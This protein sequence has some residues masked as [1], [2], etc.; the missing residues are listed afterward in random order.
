[1]N[2]SPRTSLL[3][4]VAGLITLITLSIPGRATETD[5]GEKLLQAAQAGDLKTIES[6]LETGVDVNSK[7]EYGATALAY[8][9]DK[10]HVEVVKFLIS[11]GADV[12]ATDRF[13]NFNPLTWAR[14]HTHDEIIQILVEA[15]AKTDLPLLLTGVQNGDEALV[16]AILNQK[17][18]SSEDLVKALTAA[19]AGEN[20]K[21][22]DMLKEAGAELPEGGAITVAKEALDAYA[23]KYKN[24]Q[25]G[26]E[27]T[28]RAGENKVL[29]IVAGQQELSY[30]PI[31]QVA[32]DSVEF[33][34]IRLI[35]VMKDDKCVGMKS[36]QAQ[37][38]LDWERVEETPKTA[39]ATPNEAKTDEPEVAFEEPKGTVTK[40]ANWARFRGPGASGIADGQ[41]PPTRW[42]ATTGENILWKAPIPGL[43][44]SS[45]IVWG[46]R[47]FVTTA[48]STAAEEEF[49]HGLYGDFAYAEDYDLVHSW[50]VIC[51]DR[52]SG[53]KIWERTAHEGKPRIKRHTKSS[54]T[55]STPVTDGKYVV[56]ILGSEGLFCY[57]YEGN[58]VW[59]KDLGLL[60]AGWFYDPEYQFGFGSSPFLYE[61]LVIVQAD[62][63]K[64]PFL[65]AYDIAT[66]KEA[67]RVDRDEICSWSSPNVFEV[68]G[69]AELV[70]NGTKAIRGHDPKTGK[71]L[72]R[73]VGNSEVCVPTPIMAHGLIYITSGYRPFQPIYALRPGGEGD[74]SL[75]EG[76]ETNDFVAW[77]K[78]RGGPYMQTP[79]VYGDHLYTCADNGI[80][81][82]YNAKT[83]ERLYR[84][85]LGIGRGYTASSVAADGRIY[86]TGE[87]GD[88][89]VVKA[90]REYQRIAVNSMDEVCMATPAISNGMMIVRTQHHVFGCGKSD[91]EAA[92]Q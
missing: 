45:P 5:G 78:R 88:I 61:N 71:E 49:K 67:W 33:P 72:W 81:A 40:P 69:R 15:G 38:N 32:F 91:S 44:H 35:F 80:I 19:V 55:D 60:D 31:S 85:R 57:D 3:H 13:Y 53:E 68:G 37:A 27:F 75:A 82:C 59:K 17:K 12:E 16:G 9:C 84:S 66:G 46:D 28:I 22:I 36:E 29:G 58:L 4:W 23:G 6:L 47:I 92:S 14:I 73:L 48:V 65:A 89:V 76:K 63:Q 39:D 26:L 1:M 30:A 41:Y 11:K 77:S 87:D 7:S 62:I 83:G 51:L 74:I 21:I 25:Y 20:T 70:T 79:L 34:G 86:F 64:T 10:G 2:Q 42:S 54:H 18:M 56:T 52:R 90:G 50:R 24:K 43:G 8:A